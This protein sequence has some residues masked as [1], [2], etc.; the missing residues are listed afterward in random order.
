MR[1]K[2]IAY[3]AILSIFILVFPIVG[4]KIII[5]KKFSLKTND[6]RGLKE[7]TSKVFT[8]TNHYESQKIDPSR[9]THGLGLLPYTSLDNKLTEYYFFI[10]HTAMN[11]FKLDGY[12]CG[13]HSTY[14]RKIFEKHG[15]K[16]FTYVHGIDGTK[17]THA[18]VIAEYKDNLYIFDP[19]FNYVYRYDDK[20]LTFGEVINLVKQKKSL[21]KFIQIINPLDK[22]FNMKKRIYESYT[23][24][25]IINWFNQA[26][27]LMDENKD[28]LLLNGI[29]MYAT[30]GSMEYFFEKYP[31]LK[32]LI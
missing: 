27:Y 19:T 32:S 1:K 8:F 12:L 22:V 21:K 23:S 30:T 4:N 9:L 17:Y 2:I 7:L 26:K 20:Y 18:I 16:S 13:G 25:Q 6:L 29:G 15:I 24:D 28:H 31:Y 14:L 5:E 11:Y 10:Y 3:F